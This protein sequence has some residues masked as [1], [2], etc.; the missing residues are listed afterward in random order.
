MPIS[1]EFHVLMIHSF[2]NLHGNLKGIISTLDQ[3]ENAKI[4]SIQAKIGRVSKGKKPYIKRILSNIASNITKNAENIC[5]FIIAEP[6]GIG[7]KES[8]A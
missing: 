6:S 4:N 1:P 5:D 8:T 3:E 2:D 7:I